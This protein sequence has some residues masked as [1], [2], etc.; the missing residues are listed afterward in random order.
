MEAQAEVIGNYFGTSLVGCCPVH[1]ILV[2]LWF[3]VR[4]WRFYSVGGFSQCCGYHKH[5]NCFDQKHDDKT[6]LLLG[7]QFIETPLHDL[8]REDPTSM[9]L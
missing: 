4:L 1:V 9:V 3:P 8:L 6:C 7:I 5:C 2:E